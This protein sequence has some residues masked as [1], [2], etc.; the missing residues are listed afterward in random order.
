[1]PSRCARHERPLDHAAE[2]RDELAPSH[3]LA[4]L[5][6]YGPAQATTWGR[7]CAA[8]QKSAA[9]DR[10]GSD[11]VIRRCRLNVRIARRRTWLKGAQ[12]L[13]LRR[14]LARAHASSS[15]S[16]S[17]TTIGER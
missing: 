6:N 9:D 7:I 17:T 3:G 11:S 10:I 5:P 4:M 13:I 14:R 16:G 1:M 8:Q 12:H 2:K 15:K